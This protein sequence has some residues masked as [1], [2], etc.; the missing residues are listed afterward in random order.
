MLGQDRELQLRGEEALAQHGVRERDARLGGGR[1]AVEEVCVDPR[2]VVARALGLAAPRPGHDRPVARAHQ[3][4]ELGLR[5]AQRA[6]GRVG[7]LG[8]EL[9]RLVLGD[10]RQAQLGALLQHR[11]EPVRRH[12]QVVRVLVVEARGHVLPVVAQRRRQ[13][14]LGRHRDQS[15]GRH[16]VEQLAEAVHGQHVGH[17]GALGLVARGRDL[18]QLALLRGELGRRGDLHPLGLL[19][20]ALGEG[21]EPREPLHLHVEELAAHRALLRGRVDVEDVPARG[22]LPAVLH[23]VHALVAARHELVGGLLEIEQAA[24]LD[25]EAVRAEL[26]VRAPSRRG[27]PRRSRARPAARR[28]AR[29]ARPRA[30]PRG[31]AAARGATRSARRAPGRS[32]PAGAPGRRA[33]RPPGRGRRDRPRPPPAPGARGRCRSATRA[34]RGAGSTT[35]TRAAAHGARPR[36]GR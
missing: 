13:L 26:R 19:E 36:R 12:V 32:G 22:E 27:R 6:G 15:V 1:P 7:A 5:L 33:G 29:R 21:R 3:L 34:D 31:A 24:L 23:L 28:G 4:L 20:R 11:V 30:A 35:R 25:L 14:L 8:A 10:A 18:G 9:V 2:E 16:E 17:V